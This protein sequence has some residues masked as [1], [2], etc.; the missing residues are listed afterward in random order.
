MKDS[1][2][3]LASDFMLSAELDQLAENIIPPAGAG[4][5]EY[6]P[7][8]HHVIGDPVKASGNLDVD[9][10]GVFS[11][12]SPTSSQQAKVLVTFEQIVGDDHDRGAETAVRKFDQ[13]AISM[14]NR[15]ALVPRWVQAGSAG[16]C[17]GT[18]IVFNRPCFAREFGGGDYAHAR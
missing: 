8:C 12:Q 14:V 5:L 16:D 2:E 4:V 1:L 7:A 11:L 3:L 6:L 18:G 10:A 17:S 13:F 15:V 9:V